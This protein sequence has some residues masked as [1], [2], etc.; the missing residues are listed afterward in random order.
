MPIQAIKILL[1]GTG[2][3]SEIEGDNFPPTYT[4]N[5]W[6]S[7]AEY[8]LTGSGG[9][10]SWTGALGAIN[11][12]QQGNNDWTLRLA[13]DGNYPIATLTNN[14]YTIPPGVYTFANGTATVIW[15]TT[16]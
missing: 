14:A 16:E 3:I 12:I 2:C 10:W 11:L 13:S 6:D 5:G 8:R 15:E 7:T 4:T 9:N 1:T